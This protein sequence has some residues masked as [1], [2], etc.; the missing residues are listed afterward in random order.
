M[1][2]LLAVFGLS[3]STACSVGDRYLIAPETLAAIQALT[4]EARKQTVA[5]AIRQKGGWNVT[6][7]TDA[8]SVPEATTRPDGQIAI[9]TRMR[10]KKIQLG[11]VLVWIGTPLS[12]AGLCMVIFGHDAVR[13]S[14]IAL[15]GAAEPVMIAGTVVWV[16]GSNAHP[17]EVGKGVPEL[18]YLPTPGLP[19]SGQT[20]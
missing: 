15:A 10:S 11:N 1:R 6:V 12:I 19:V 16:Q 8:F 17:Q 13:W 2:I 3:V 5:P 14:G 9:P 20:P 7:R 18:N 4:P